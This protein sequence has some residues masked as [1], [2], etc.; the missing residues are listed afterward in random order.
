MKRCLFLEEQT[1]ENVNAFCFFHSC[2]NKRL[3]IMF[4]I[5]KEK[6]NISFLFERLNRKFL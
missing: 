4:L 3:I 6:G 1:E 5:E 2:K